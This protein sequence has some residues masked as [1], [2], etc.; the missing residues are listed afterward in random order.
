MRQNKEKQKKSN[1]N[2]FIYYLNSGNKLLG[3]SV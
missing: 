2:F 1:Q 3:I